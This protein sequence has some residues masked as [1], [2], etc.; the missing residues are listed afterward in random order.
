MKCPACGAAEMVR[1]T[2]DVPFTYKRRTTIIRSMTA[3]FCPECGE[4]IPDQIEGERISAL[5]LAFKR[6]VDALP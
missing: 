4:S 6:E 1:D 2:R 3:D 5:M